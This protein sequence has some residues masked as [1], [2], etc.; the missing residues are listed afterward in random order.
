[1]YTVAPAIT[2]QVTILRQTEQAKT[3]QDL[4]HRKVSVQGK[5]EIGLG[6]GLRAQGDCSESVE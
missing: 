6:R 4:R 2:F 5:K 1:M 3:S